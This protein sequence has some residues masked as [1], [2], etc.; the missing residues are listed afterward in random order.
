[1]H[2]RETAKVERAKK[3]PNIFSSSRTFL[4]LSAGCWPCL[5][6]QDLRCALADCDHALRFFDPDHIESSSQAWIVWQLRGRIRASLGS[7]DFTHDFAMAQ[8]L[9]PG[10]A[11]TYL[12]KGRCLWRLKRFDEAKASYQQGV[13]HP[14]A[15]AIKEEFT[16]ELHELEKQMA[17]WK[18]WQDEE[19]QRCACSVQ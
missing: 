1:M 12:L 19:D 16:N 10:C 11:M 5:S 6:Q 14:H 7:D 9:D 2:M 8:K 4:L 18:K 3:V 13:N 15:S 17:A